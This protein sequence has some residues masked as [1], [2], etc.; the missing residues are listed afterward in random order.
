MQRSRV[1]KNNLK[2][3][4]I[5][6]LHYWILKLTIKQYNSRRNQRT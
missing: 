6:E 4:N 3:N 1:A 5:R 2:K